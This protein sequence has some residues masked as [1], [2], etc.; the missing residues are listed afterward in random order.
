MGNAMRSGVVV[1]IAAVIAVVFGSPSFGKGS[2]GGHSHSDS[3]GS[4]HWSG[5]TSHSSGS[6]HHHNNHAGRAHPSHGHIKR[7]EQAKDEFMH[8]HPCPSTDRTS[9]SCPGYVIDHVVP[10]KR[11][12]ADEA[13]NMRWL[14][15]EDATD[16][17]E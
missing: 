7:S 10:L 2:S 17:L 9:G 13:T 1:A 6:S 11:G 8:S 12:G 3:S 4:H 15:V 14:T 16:K 5:S